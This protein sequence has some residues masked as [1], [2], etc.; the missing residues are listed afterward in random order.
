V[1]EVAVDLLLIWLFSFFTGAGLYELVVPDNI[2]TYYLYPILAAGLGLLQ[3]AIICAYL[4]YFSASI[5][6]ASYISA[7]VGVTTLILALVLNAHDLK[8]MRERMRELG[9]LFSLRALAFAGL[10]CLVL[11]PVWAAR[12]ATTPYRIGIDQVGYAQAAQY[13]LEGGTLKKAAGTLLNDLQTRDLK[14]AE[15][16]NIL[17]LNFE[18]FVDSD[19]LLKAFRWGFPGAVAAL[20][21]LTRSG[22]VFRIEFLFLIFSYALTLGL[23]FQILKRYFML[24]SNA[25]FAATAALGLNCN[26]L[27]VYYEGQLA[28]VF[29]TPFFLLLFAVYLYVR[30]TSS[31]AIRSA[32]LFAFLIAGI[33][34]S[35][36]EAIVL[37]GALFYLILL[38][39]F[40]LY[41]KT[42]RP[43]MLVLTIGFVAGFAAALPIS[44][45]WLA[46]TA[47]NLQGLARGGFWQPHWASL[48]EIL[49][50]LNMYGQIGYALLP[51]S[52]LNE[53]LSM[54][55]SVVLACGVLLFIAREKNLDRAFWLAPLLLIAA[56]YVH[57]HY[58]AQILNYSYMKIYTML[59]PLAACVVF[60][61][62][63]SLTSSRV[64][65]GKL[66]S[67]GAVAVVCLTGMSYIGQYLVESQYVTKDMFALYKFQHGRRFDND[68][69]MMPRKQLQ[70][71]IQE[72][73]LAPLISMNWLN[74][75]VFPKSLLSY[76][77]KRV[78]TILTGEDA[79]LQCLVLNHPHQVEYSN[80]SY[81][82]FDSGLMVHDVCP[83][84]PK[85]YSLDAGPSV[86]R[87]APVSQCDPRFFSRL[88]ALR[89][90]VLR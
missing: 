71:A 10:L 27:N 78:I 74:E 29:I 23:A 9:K 3:L 17:T 84:D 85:M 36:N 65:L 55:L 37:I 61:A 4:I 50:F 83:G 80:P 28:Q 25:A 59:I 31:D 81:V 34:S 66:M 82:V 47:A 73:M 1:V 21:L 49:G 7:G 30:K 40:C 43:A 60:A 88:S 75:G 45:G 18:A 8:P 52:P 38:L 39:D 64:K 56:A 79:C 76:D 48:A 15:A 2:K 90:S 41:R 11:A 77:K 63:F 16:Q 89:E 86:W 42:N 57:V 13:L 24:T 70:A 72:Y 62:I 69:V 5:V 44:A 20:T 26:L 58:I 22:H 19:F 35:Y 32:I 33:F 68:A 54:G 6:S 67:Y 87:G 46:Y 53:L 14:K 12:M 51:R